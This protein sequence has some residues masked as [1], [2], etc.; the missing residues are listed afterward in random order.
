MTG[1]DV[2]FRCGEQVDRLERIVRE[3]MQPDTTPL[4]FREGASI[5]EVIDPARV[6][7]I[8]RGAH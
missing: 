6:M 4:Y 7:Y 3:R 1:R 8:K 5:P 2:T